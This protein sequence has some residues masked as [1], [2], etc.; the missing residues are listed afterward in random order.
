MNNP[1]L[2]DLIDKADSKYTLAVLAAKR[3]REIIQ[4]SEK[5]VASKS[6]KPVTIAL[7][8]IAQGKISFKRTNIGI[9]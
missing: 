6:S 7:E 9:K 3:A 5:S 8:E 4:D 2:E 1:A